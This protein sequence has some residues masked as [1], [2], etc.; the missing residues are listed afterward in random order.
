LTGARGAA[1]D[2]AREAG[3]KQIFADTDGKM[4]HA[5]DHLHD[6]LKR[7]RTGRA[8]VSMLDGVV[9]DY[10]GSPVPLN[11]VATLTAADA[12]LL[13]AQPFDPSQITNIERALRKSDLGLNPSNDGKVIRI[14][15]PQPT[16]ERRKELVRKA[17]DFAEQARIAVREARREANE[18]LK[19]LGK[20][21][22]VGQDEERRG[23]D[24]IQKLHD[25]HVDE[26]GKALEHKEKDILTV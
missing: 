1:E 3:M 11:N 21:G 17:H 20:D 9:V 23:H 12:T 26:I 25:R 4:R 18:R 15:V 10:Y 5:V 16:E 19:K 6:E 2:G 13:V 24:E 8:S 22:D 14:P 7:L